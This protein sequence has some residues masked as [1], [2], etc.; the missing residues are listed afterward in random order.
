MPNRQSGFEIFPL[1]EV[2]KRLSAEENNVMRGRACMMIATMFMRHKVASSA[3]SEIGMRA[4][5]HD[6]Q[7]H[8]MSASAAAAIWRILDRLRPLVVEVL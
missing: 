3:Q 5:T 2:E 7:S 4:R 1:K 6:C 8:S